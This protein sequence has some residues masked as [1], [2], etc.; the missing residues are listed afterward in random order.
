M[1]LA[2]LPAPLSSSGPPNF[3]SGGYCGTDRLGNKAG[4]KSKLVIH[5]SK[6]EVTAKVRQKLSLAGDK[7]PFRRFARLSLKPWKIRAQMR[8][9]AELVCI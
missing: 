4:S 9:T 3:R 2:R 8:G 6:P 5:P 1:L 7:S